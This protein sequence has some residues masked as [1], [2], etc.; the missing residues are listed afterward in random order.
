MSDSSPV[1]APEFDTGPWATISLGMK[2]LSK[3]GRLV[4]SDGHLGLLRENG[5]L[6]ESAPLSAVEVKKGMLY[7]LVPTL[8]LIVGGNKYKLMLSYE[9]SIHGGLGD[10]QAKEV[11]YEDNDRLSEVVRKHG[12]KA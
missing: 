10:Q 1:I 8:Q 9:R 2:V 6:I 11:Q 5:D 12:G 4:V 3:R 7:S